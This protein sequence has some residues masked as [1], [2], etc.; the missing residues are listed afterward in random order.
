VTHRPTKQITMPHLPR[1]VLAGSAIALLAQLPL[2]GATAV[3]DGGLSVTPAVIERTAVRGDTTSMTVVNGTSK[4]L[5]ITVTP[6]PWTQS[7][8]G[9]V[10]PNR[11]KTL[12]ARVG[13]SAR[14]F[15]LAPGAR[16][17]VAM[18]V[19]SL[20]SSGSLYGS[21]E[22]IG[23]PTGP[24][25]KNGITAAYRLIS[26][27]RLNPPS[28]K[29]RLRVRASGL[30]VT[31]GTIALPVRNTGNTVSPISGDVR[32]KGPSGTRTTTV[33]GR[34]IL[35]GAT[36]DLALGSTKGLPSGRY[37]VTVALKQ[38]GRKVASVTRR[39]RVK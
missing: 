33:S 36:V 4:T 38:D 23:L 31:R 10:V 15:T 5:R 1:L 39:L 28:A 32:F 12:L 19:K 26:T 27:L 6:R 3:A 22:T 8:G 13:V 7:R 29:R 14:S 11:S 18:N 34:P 20:P 37:T 9:A 16:R 21:V 2:A 24:A 30:R 35:P 25:R 17:A